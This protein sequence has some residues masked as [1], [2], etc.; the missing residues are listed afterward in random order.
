M[1][2]SREMRRFEMDD[3]SSRRGDRNRSSRREFVE[4]FRVYS[5]SIY[6]SKTSERSYGLIGAELVAPVATNEGAECSVGCEPPTRISF[7]SARIVWDEN[8]QITNK[9]IFITD[10][11]SFPIGELIGKVIEPYYGGNDT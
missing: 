11:V 5:T 7:S 3:L 10:I 4:R 8:N 1:H 2:L 6:R 9:R